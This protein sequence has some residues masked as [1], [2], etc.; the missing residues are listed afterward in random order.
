MKLPAVN[1]YRQKTAQQTVKH[2]WPNIFI[3]LTKAGQMF[4]RDPDESET[5]FIARSRYEKF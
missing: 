1:R 2:K 3:E 5:D 4:H